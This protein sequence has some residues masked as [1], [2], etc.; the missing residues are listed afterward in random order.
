MDEGQNL[1]LSWRHFVQ[2]AVTPAEELSHSWLVEL[3]D[4]APAFA[5]GV[6]RGSGG[7]SLRQ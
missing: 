1:N 3:R 2:E 7:E 6:R 4:N 5:E